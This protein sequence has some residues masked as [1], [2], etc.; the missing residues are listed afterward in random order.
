MI[1]QT[2]TILHAIDTTGP[3]GAETVFL[4]LAQ[5]LTVEGFNNFAIIKGPGWVED[6]LKAR[7]IPYTI[8]KPYGFLSLPYYWTLF[9]LL[10]KHNVKLIQAHLLGSTLTYSILSL[11]LRIPLVATIHGQVD[12]NPNEKHVYLKNRIMR[13]G[14]DRLVAVSQQLANYIAERKL[15][16]KDQIEVIYNGVDVE[17]YGKNDSREIRDQLALEDEA[18]LIG[19]VGNVRPAKAYHIL[20][21]AAKILEQKFPHIHFVIAG[22]QKPQLMSELEAQLKRQGLESRVHFIGFHPNT[23]EFLGQM[24]MFALSSASEGF[25]IATIEAMAT[26]LAVV[27]TRCG[28]PEEILSDEDNGILVDSMSAEALS[29]AVGLIVQNPT[30]KKNISNN[31]KAHAADTFSLLTLLKKYKDL[32]KSLLNKSQEIARA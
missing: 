10:R 24:D 32:Y 29:K 15:F 9:R 28:G 2:P 16:K 17:R 22:H 4:D 20:I 19:C 1:N 11:L 18:F 26:G 3:G 8:V 5:H 21:D 25:S 14:V 31:G 27:A 13:C 7:G 30:L 12:I 6:Q 23:A